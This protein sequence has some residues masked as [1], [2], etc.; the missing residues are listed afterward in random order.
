VKAEHHGFRGFDLQCELEGLGSCCLSLSGS[1]LVTPGG[2]RLILLGVEDIT[3][4]KRSEAENARLFHEAEAARASAEDASRTKDL[5]LATLSHELRTPLST[6]LL[7]A[8][9]LRRR[10]MGEDQVRST[11]EAIEGATL[12]QARLIDDLLDISRIV[13]GKLKIVLRSVSLSAVVQAAVASISAA[14]ARKQIELQL[15][16][17]EAL[18]RVSGDPGRLQQVVSNLLTNA[19]KFTP[20]GGRV[21]V[22]VDVLEGMGRLRVSDS[23]VGIEPSFL[24][25]VFD[26]FTQEEQNQTRSPGG[27]GLGLAIVRNLVEAHGGSIQVE[28]G[29]RGKGAT[30]TALL[31][32]ARTRELEAAPEPAE[33]ANQEGLGL[34][35]ISG[36][37]VLIVEDNV[38]TREALS[39]MLRSFG[40]EVRAAE[41]ARATL[42]LV[43]E[44][45]PQLLVCDIAMPDQDGYTLLGRIRA[46]G[47]DRGGS[48]PAVAFTAL[49]SEDDGRRALEAG[50]Q[51][52]VAK[53]VGIE[54]LV[55][56]LARLVKGARSTTNPATHAPAP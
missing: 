11:C 17:A 44:F 33:P 14:A 34:G 28:S 54:R 22:T 37:R 30:F 2:G 20:D 9:R 35:D 48:V 16:I 32:L 26:R 21:S 8:Q 23:G 19:V 49:A 15:H 36:V 7:H 29:G 10:T 51:T 6:L 53:P 45:R 5:F 39:E 42:A 55:P 56:E 43:E 50:F 25:Q 24:P 27:L 31:P 12:A 41:S 47:P 46:L 38:G 18:P 4:R 1:S 13:S 40:A 52:H 3:A